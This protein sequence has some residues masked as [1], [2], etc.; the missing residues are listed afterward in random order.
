MLIVPAIDVYGG[1]CV[2]LLQGAFSRSTRYAEDPVAA[3]SRFQ[4][5]G[6]RVIHVV[7]LD[8]AEG[9]GADNRAV[10]ARIRAAVSARLQ[11]G[12]GVRSEDDAR[13]LKEMGIQRIV[14]G[15]PLAR[16][17]EQVGSWAVRLGG[18]IVGGID[19]R[20]GR[21]KVSGWAEDTPLLDTELAARS[22]AL[23]LAGLV[24][25]N[26]SRDGMLE[27]PDIE[28]T[29]RVAEAAGLPTLLS[30]GIG[31][32]EHVEKVFARGHPRLHG[33]IIGKAIYEGTVKLTDLIRRF[34]TDL[35]LTW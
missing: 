14:V 3:A 23:G 22:S 8:A 26:I 12:G 7:D 17:P 13:A 34:D 2:R 27:G 25:T 19:A 4:D 5:D 1:R 24:Y 15:T 32:A 16:A 28:R 11:V 20:D 18:C 30:G 35:S 31:T 33:V 6:A 10:I 9:K 29:C 21:V